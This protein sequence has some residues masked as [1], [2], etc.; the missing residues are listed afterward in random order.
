MVLRI[1]Y[2]YGYVRWKKTIW[3]AMEN[4]YLRV[5][6]LFE[7]AVEWIPA[8]GNKVEIIFTCITAIADKKIM[9]V[10]CVSEVLCSPS[11]SAVQIK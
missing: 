4:N 6:K 7:F 1:F 5:Y 3:W 10:F 2:L 9:S 8:M 11:Q